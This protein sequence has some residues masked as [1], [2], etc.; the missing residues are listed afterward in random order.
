[1]P[2]TVRHSDEALTK[3]AT[4]QLSTWSTLGAKGTTS[5]WG[6][7]RPTR[8]TMKSRL[9]RLSWR[10]WT[11]PVRWSC[12][13]RLGDREQAVL[14]I[15]GELSLRPPAEPRGPLRREVLPNEPPG[16]ETSEAEQN[17][18]SRSER[19]TP[20]CQPG[21]RSPARGPR[22]NKSDA[23]ALGRQLVTRRIAPGTGRTNWSNKKS[24]CPSLS[25]HR[26]G[27]REPWLPDNATVPR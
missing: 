6:R 10:C 13:G 14:V 27:T 4:R 1:M 7:W 18:R 12:P 17:L 19:R 26:L 23:I 20:S 15:G 3:P 25:R 9:F 11:S 8:E 2:L 21:P 5:S 22:R 24:V 16:S